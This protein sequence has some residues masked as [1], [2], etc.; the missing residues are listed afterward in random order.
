MG[1]PIRVLVLG[2]HVLTRTALRALLES[3]SGIQ[4]LGDHSI[5]GEGFSAARS[6]TPDV[7]LVELSDGKGST[8][9]VGAV[10]EL[11]EGVSK[12]RVAVVGTHCERQFVS[13]LLLK[14]VLGYLTTDSTADELCQ[15]LEVVAG[16]RRYLTPS[17][18]EV[19]VQGMIDQMTGNQPASALSKL[20]PRERD[21]LTM[22][23]EGQTSAQAARSLHISVHTVD[24][25]RRNLME[26]LNLHSLAAVIRF[27][28]E[29]GIT[30]SRELSGAG[31]G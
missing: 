31:R 25:H 24:T 13:A 1:R 20:S 7:V 2:D 6:L 3:R 17:A 16:D 9:G 15:A 12:A 30:S 22:I 19:V 27:A 28:I 26:K 21:V 23:A 18:S 8:K 5:A 29:H 10:G 4:V 14:G 11:F